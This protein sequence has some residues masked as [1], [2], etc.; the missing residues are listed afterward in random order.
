M[1][2]SVLCVFLLILYL[3]LVCTM[4]SAKIEEEMATLVQVERRTSSKGTGRTMTLDFR[5]VFTDSEGD[6]LYEV[7]EGEGWSHGLRAYEVTGF[8][9]DFMQ[10][11]VT[12]YGP[13]DYSF[14]KSASRQPKDGELVKIVEEFEM[15]KDTYLYCYKYG[16][17]E[18]LD[19][20][21]YLTVVGQSESAL[22]IENSEGTFPFL[23]HTAKTWTVT[24]DAANRVFSLSEACRFLKE[25]PKVTLAFTLLI[26]GVLLLLI[27]FLLLGDRKLLYGNIATI[28]S[29]TGLFGLV[30]SKIDFPASLLPSSNIL[31]LEYYKNEMIL[32]GKELECM[33]EQSYNILE[34]MNGV[35]RQCACI[36]YTGILFVGVI[37]LFEVII[38]WRKSNGEV[39]MKIRQYFRKVKFYDKIL[40]GKYLAV[41]GVVSSIVTLI[42]FFITA[43]DV[44]VCSVY[45]LIIFCAAV[46]GIFLYMW[47]AANQ[48]K[49]ADLR[50]NNTKVCVAEGDIWALMKKEPSDRTEE[51]SVIAVN[52][53]YDIIVDD[54]IV[55]AKSLHGQYIN[56]LIKE[57]KLD[58]LNAVIENDNVLNELN[59]CEKVPQ[60]TKGRQM[61]YAIGSVVEFESYVL[62][63][64]TKF[65]EHNKA[66]LSAE[67]YTSFW[68]HFW[69][70]IDGIYA[71]RTINIPLI[72]AGITRFR[73]GKPS[74]Q[75]LL[76]IMLWTL[77]ISGFH[78]TY[79]DSQINII[80]YPPD[81]NEIDFYHI[82]HNRNYH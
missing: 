29:V 17:P 51:V 4:L 72:G 36:F 43:Q 5:A 1:K 12:L 45:L 14:V 38:L 69:E 75:E 48:V 26:I 68:M 20:P 57:E 27:S 8:S 62:A 82:Q 39:V 65:D 81:A 19:M 25:L 63:A 10:G 76:E 59:N 60:R 35:Q 74:K 42:S 18:E 22:L 55:A 67:E 47:W 79:A 16:V 30:L 3:L 58:A 7:R 34:L 44:G 64:F 23:P 53:Y 77:K 80:I 71:G 66:F 15:G 54:R 50:I 46:I 33:A 2:R 40:W 21:P 11:V 13:R 52:D 28:V 78:N 24:T 31:D 70:N 73:N 56:K 49:H 32:I 41:L 6:R 9:L 37:V 61:R